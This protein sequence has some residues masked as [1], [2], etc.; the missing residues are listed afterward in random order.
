MDRLIT[1][2]VKP[3]HASALRAGADRLAGHW[4]L[5]PQSPAYPNALSFRTH[6]P[7]TPELV[8]ER[9]SGLAVDACVQPWPLPKVALFIADMDSTMI[10]VECIDELAAEAGIRDQV[11]RITDRAMAG[12]L[13][14]EDSLRARVGLLKGLPVAVLDHVYRDKVR[15]SPG[16]PALMQSLN[17]AGVHTLLASGGFTAFTE[18]V[19]AG[20]GFDDHH[21]NRLEVQDG[22]LTGRVVPPLFGAD[23]KAAVLCQAMADLGVGPESTVAVGDGANDVPMVR[24]AGRG[25]GHHPKPALARQALASLNHSGLDSLIAFLGL[26]PLT[27]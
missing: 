7:V 5:E 6:A 14:F 11:T 16:A 1:L 2:A 26:P 21:A 9:L 24:L 19:A 20:L 17:K 12:E 4:P 10:T 25:F 18:K 3:E 22:R 13:N 8:A 15:F 23:G 27:I